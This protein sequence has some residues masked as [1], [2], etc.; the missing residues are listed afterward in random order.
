MGKIVVNIKTICFELAPLKSIIVKS[1]NDFY[2]LVCDLKIQY[3]VWFLTFN[4]LII[5]LFITALVELLEKFVLHLSESPS[6]CY[7][8]SVEYTGTI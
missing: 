7:F 3:H 6:E 5:L 8:P 2:L 1:S 4:I